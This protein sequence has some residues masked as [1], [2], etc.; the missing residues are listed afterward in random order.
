[1]TP[2]ANR[3]P[4]SWPVWVGCVIDGGAAAAFL[5]S[6]WCLFPTPDWNEVRLAP[7]F[8]LRH[9]L[10]VYPPSGGGPLSTWIYGPLPLVLNLP[11]T[12][13]SS[14]T[15]ALEIAG[16]INALTL[17]AP[18]VLVCWTASANAPQ[19]AVLRVWSIA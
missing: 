18:L 12:F 15:G 16:A 3:P 8:A 6:T 11:A 17:L 13:A 7:A 5:W 19:R 1:M 10:V 2:A 14:A 9:G 4:S